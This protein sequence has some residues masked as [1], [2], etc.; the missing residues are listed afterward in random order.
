MLDVAQ[1]SGAPSKL[2]ARSQLA[3]SHFLAS[4]H[5]AGDRHA[6]EAAA[7]PLR[8]YPAGID[9]VTEG[10]TTDRL[11]VLTE[12]W[13]CRYKTTRD[14][15]RQIVA[16]IVPGEV[17]NL[18]TLM[19]DQPDYGVRSLTPVKT[20]AITCEDALALAAS[21]PG[22]G[23]TLTRLALA[24]N[25][26]L[27]QWALCL[28]RQ[29]ARQRL[30]HLLCELGERLVPGAESGISFELPLTQE[31]I[32]DALG[33]TPVHVNRTLQ[34][35]RNDGLVE[36]S[37]RTISLPDISRLRDLAGFDATYLHGERADRTRPEHVGA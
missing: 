22:I 29:S 24:E 3:G 7:Q 19:F 23:R 9:L 25:A 30:A 31:Q 21:H 35:L 20:V 4:F 8:P 28:G 18:D 17:A 1:H 34:Q 5:D 33:L 6:L 16:L 11:L 2:T 14:G 32:A 26:I 10:H 36:T 12:G 27:R 13:A 15:S 37:S